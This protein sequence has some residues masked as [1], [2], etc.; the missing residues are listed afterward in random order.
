MTEI[1]MTI[2]TRERE[3]EMMDFK[4]S[5]EKRLKQINQNK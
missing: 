4:L 2:E 3:K 5:N 1:S